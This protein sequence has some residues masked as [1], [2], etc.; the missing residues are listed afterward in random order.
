MAIEII[1]KKDQEKPSFLRR[2]T[3]SLG[4]F[5]L[6][7]SIA[8]TAAFAFFEIK[9]DQEKEDIDRMIQDR[10]TDE[11]RDLEK[12]IRVHSRKVNN[13][14]EIIK[15][16]ALVAPFF[17]LVEDSLHPL[18]ILT[19]LQVDVEEKRISAS[20]IAATIV[21]F[22]QQVKILENNPLI[23]SF[24]IPNF[25][26]REDGNITFPIVINISEEALNSKQ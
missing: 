15:E 24:S 6:I 19:N 23:K 8:A 17:R 11:I 16:R 12:R 18:V 21:S 20:G 22:D 1:P 10:K 13:F 3:L 9:F 4:I 14:S 7:S 5:L 26:R 2:F 25:S